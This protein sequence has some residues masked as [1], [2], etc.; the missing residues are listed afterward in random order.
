[1]LR[2]AILYA[3]RAELHRWNSVLYLEMGSLIAHSAQ[4]I[5]EI[6]EM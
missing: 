5:A 4:L 1:M 2:I 3:L 6:I